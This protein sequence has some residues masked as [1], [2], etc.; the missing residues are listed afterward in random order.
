ME[1]QF[2]APK[3]GSVARL[4]ELYEKRRREPSSPEERTRLKDLFRKEASAHP[5]NH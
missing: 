2:K 4:R 5:G 1:K 3:K